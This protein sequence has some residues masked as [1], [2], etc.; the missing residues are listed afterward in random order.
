MRSFGANRR[1]KL[2]WAI[3][4]C[5]SLLIDQQKCLLHWRQQLITKRASPNGLIHLFEFV[6]KPEGLSLNPRP[7]NQ[8]THRTLCHRSRNKFDFASKILD[9]RYKKSSSGDLIRCPTLCYKIHHKCVCTQNSAPH[10]SRPFTFVFIKHDPYLTED[11]PLPPCLWTKQDT[12]S[13]KSGLVSKVCFL[14]L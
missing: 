5:F 4:R 8:F 12:T 6:R 10:V 7:T 14:H 1:T 2:Q 9:K 3:Y 13:N 11:P